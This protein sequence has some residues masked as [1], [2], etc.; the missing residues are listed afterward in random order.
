L[1]IHAPLIAMSKADIV[2]KAIALGVD[3]A[4]TSSCYDPEPSGAPC[5]RCDACLLRARGF[6]QAGVVDP[7]LVKF[8]L[9]S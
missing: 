3:C 2:Q 4:E 9:A 6:E 1:T 5:Q 8:G 7:L